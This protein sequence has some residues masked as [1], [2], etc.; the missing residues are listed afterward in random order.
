MKNHTLGMLAFLA[1]AAVIAA[2]IVPNFLR[3]QSRREFM[4]CRSNLKNIGLALEIY[5]HQEKK[6]Y[7]DSLKSLVPDILVSIPPC[8]AAGED[9]YS[10]TYRYFPAEAGEVSLYDAPADCDQSCWQELE[11]A[12][13]ALAELPSDQKTVDALPESLQ[14]CKHGPFQTGPAR[15]AY[16]FYCAGHRHDWSG[17]PANYPVFD[18]EHGLVDR[19]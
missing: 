8:P 6:V 17:V 13:R 2:N 15:G 12:E 18:S 19:P 10:Q 3:A 14:G 5:T 1:I 7:P 16:S 4:S 11:E 9:V